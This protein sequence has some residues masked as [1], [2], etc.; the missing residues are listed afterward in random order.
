VGLIVYFVVAYIFCFYFFPFGVHCLSIILDL[1]SRSN[2][3]YYM[4][5]SDTIYYL[6]LH[7]IALIF[8]SASYNAN[9]MWQTIQ[10]RNLKILS[11]KIVSVIIYK[12]IKKRFFCLTIFLN[13][14]LLFVAL[15]LISNII[16]PHT[17]PISSVSLE[18]YFF[19]LFSLSEDI[20]SK[21]YLISGV[22]FLSFLLISCNS[23]TLI[24]AASMQYH[25]WETDSIQ[26]KCHE[27]R[28][29]HWRTE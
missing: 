2:I 5:L 4:A 26:N 8:L 9:D 24:I 29:I 11:T 7:F 10:D 12:Q 17:D 6:T 18:E 16:S 22:Y 27:F 13:Y 23:L 25:I 3:N 14:A 20:I 15:S 21:I 19:N 1:S 28:A